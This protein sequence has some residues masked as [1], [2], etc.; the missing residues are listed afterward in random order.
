MNKPKVLA[1]S[2]WGQSWIEI[3]VLYVL[4]TVGTGM[5]F[6]LHWLVAMATAP[7]VMFAMLI[8]VMAIVQVLW[9]SVVAM[10]KIGNAVGVRKSPLT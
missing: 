3:V 7:A 2:P 5:L 4:T 9:M 6:Q 10:D 8:T 1:E